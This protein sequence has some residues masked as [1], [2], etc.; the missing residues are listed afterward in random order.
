MKILHSKI[1]P[2]K[3][4]A[5]VI[6]ARDNSL[7]D[8]I[9][10]KRITMVTA[11]AGYGK[12]TFIAKATAA[13]EAVWYRLAEPDNDLFVFLNY[14]S[15]GIGRVYP[16]FSEA[17]RG[18][19]DGESL[20]D[21]DI[22]AVTVYYLHVMENTIERNLMIVLDDFHLV[23]E[24]REVL[25]CVQFLV[26]HLPPAVHIILISRAQVKLALSRF[27]VMG[28]VVDVTEKDLVFTPDETVRLF[29]QTLGMSLTKETVSKVHSRSKGWIA[30][31]IM[32]YHAL[33]G[34]DQEEI[35]ELLK[36]LKGSGRVIS[37]YLEENVFSFLPDEIRGFLLKT[38]LLSRL[39]R[40][41][42]DRFL[43][44]NDSGDILS[45]LEKNHLFTHSLDDIGQEYYYHH[46]FQDFLLSRLAAEY[47]EGEIGNLHKKAGEIYEETGMMEEAIT[48]YLDAREYAGASRA[49]NAAGLRMI[50]E[51]RMR[52]VSTFLD[53]FPPDMINR[54]PQLLIL[55]A[56]LSHALGMGQEAIEEFKR[57]RDMFNEQGLQVWAD[58]CEFSLLNAYFP[59][60]Y[61]R[62]AEEQINRALKNPACDLMV[63][64]LLVAQLVFITGYLGKPH[65]ADRYFNEGMTYAATI[66]DKMQRVE[67][68]A[69]LLCNHSIRFMRSGDFLDAVHRCEQAEQLIIH[70]DNNRFRCQLYHQA[71][72][73]Y[74]FAGLYE[75]GL[76]NS[77]S[78]LKLIREKGFRDTTLGWLL[79]ASSI[80]TMGMKRY[81]EAV[82]Q[83]RQAMKFFIDTGSHWGEVSSCTALAMA[84]MRM[85]DLN[86]AEEVTNQGLKK[87]ETKD[88]PDIK[89]QLMIGLASMRALQ[90]RTA[91]AEAILRDD[92]LENPPSK[93]LA[94][95]VACIRSC[96]ASLQS[97]KDLAIE[98]ARECLKVSQINKYDFWVVE[99]L[100]FLIVP[101]A[102]L[103]EQ[104]EMK[105]YLLSIF[106]RI[107]P[108][109]KATLHQ[110]ES[111]GIS[112]LGHACRII[113]NTLPPESPPGLKVFT[114]GK[115]QLY[116][117]DEA[118]SAQTWKSKKARM[119]FKLLIHYR[120]KGYVNKDVFME[121]LWPEENPGKTAKR[122]HVTLA[123]V[124]KM[125]E[126][127]GPLSTGT[128]SSY[129]L[130]DGD[131]YLLSLGE[132]GCV[133]L[134]EFEEACRLARETKDKKEAI[135]QLLHAAE[136]FHGDFLEEDLYETWCME[137][138]NRLKEEYLSVLASIVD[139]FESEKD[140]QKA[141]DYCG[142]YLAKDAYAEDMYQRL[143]R[144]HFF[145]GNRAMVKR[146]YERCRKS[147]V[148]DLDCP[149][150]K[151][152]EHLVKELISDAETSP[153]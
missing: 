100:P 61:F 111:M 2:P 62:E 52:L 45:Y 54:T 68:Q 20:I 76:E 93:A 69:Q 150:S 112:E 40:T 151:E 124:R 60:G 37:E 65:E 134:D 127:S 116:K 104:G 121:Q 135:L 34:K 145:L 49:L 92:L 43:G 81:T 107:D 126:P 123:T 106:Y 42:C 72:M 64:Q 10:K 148:N 115:F 83:G 97:K 117:G 84:Y 16:L 13:E 108:D 35:D 114:L 141:I 58:I 23:Q 94:W 29:D 8:E 120:S 131:N 149:L 9:C 85:G 109:L 103:Y 80:N 31:L 14:L 86:N 96:M 3:I 128:P 15:E 59:M 79:L 1:L 6:R 32:F 11:G 70:S 41:L 50:L 4:G 130:S 24:S 78:G 53:K 36:K 47:P 44:I 105:E 57:A 138:R 137:E 71:G 7:S 142:K 88:F 67:W 55:T 119:L 99:Q 113:L 27:R 22:Q 25:E 110:L 73:A 98:Y 82:E 26:E 74:A 91:E 48:H 12:T 5:T 46:L 133:D 75:K 146:T 118:I 90:G 140:Y 39:N 66:P 122:F 125:L 89:A 30:G 63:C 129:I 147:I 153:R 132:G 21:K 152:T 19:F 18:Y 77:T 143:M 51:G 102:E 87:L 139:Y 95:W 56:H 17:I 38:S 144:L 33:R 101:L 136:L 28:E